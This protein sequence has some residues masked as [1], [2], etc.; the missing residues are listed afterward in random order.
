MHYELNVMTSYHLEWLFK[1]WVWY[2]KKIDY[3]A[4][5]KIKTLV[6]NS[7]NIKNK[8]QKIYNRK[9]Y[10]LNIELFQ[11]EFDSLV[12]PIFERV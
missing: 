6:C 3:E 1:A 8:I 9:Y 2:M 12:I 5:K 11:V 7:E 10:T 4:T